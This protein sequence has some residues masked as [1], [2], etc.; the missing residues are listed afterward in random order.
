M[1]GFGMARCHRRTREPG[2][3]RRLVI[4]TAGGICTALVC[5]LVRLNREYRLETVSLG[6]PA[7][8][9]RAWPRSAGRDAPDDD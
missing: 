1:A 8:T 9:T 7:S 4:N 5:L 2:W 6:E 3:R